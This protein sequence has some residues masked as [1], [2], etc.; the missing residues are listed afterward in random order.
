M[1]AVRKNFLP[2]VSEEGKR[3]SDCEIL[4]RNQE[5][6]LK[7]GGLIFWK[8]LDIFFY[9]QKRLLPLMLFRS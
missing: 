2:P 6:L 7:D 4:I 8:T 1:K 3:V 5:T 9:I